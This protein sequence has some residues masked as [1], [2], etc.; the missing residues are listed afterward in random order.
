MLCTRCGAC[1][2]PLPLDRAHA[3]V[4]DAAFCSADCAARADGSAGDPARHRAR[5]LALVAQARRANEAVGASDVLFLDR[6]SAAN[7]ILGITKGARRRKR[8][9]EREGDEFEQRNETARFHLESALTSIVCHVMALG[10]DVPGAV[11]AAVCLA[12][13]FPSCAGEPDLDSVLATLE[14]TL[15]GLEQRPLR[16]EVLDGGRTRI[17][18]HRDGICTY[19]KEHLEAREGDVWLEGAFV[20]WSAIAKVER[21]DGEVAL[22]GESGDTLASLFPHDEA[23]KERVF[24]WVR[25]ERPEMRDAERSMTSG[26][27][28]ATPGCFLAIALLIGGGLAGLL[29]VL[30]AGAAWVGVVAGLT[31]VVSGLAIT[32]AVRR[33]VRRPVV[34]QLVLPGAL[35]EVPVAMHGGAPARSA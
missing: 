28:V 22:R 26:E 1:A 19:A 8:G 33:L 3:W 30:D 18:R 14:A 6:R 25:E 7:A 23:G 34:R 31:A 29:H 17:E 15:L 12:H 35:E 16:R 20:A 11:D 32:F 21:V 5:A 10:E 4:R 2:A 24:S 9:L 13:S 27:A